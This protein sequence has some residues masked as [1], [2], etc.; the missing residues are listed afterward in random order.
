MSIFFIILATIVVGLV[1]IFLVVQADKKRTSAFQAKADELGWPFHP[2]GDMVLLGRLS[3][4]HLFSQGHSKKMKNLLWAKSP[5]GD[6]AIFGYRYTTGGGDNSRMRRQNV[7]YFESSALKL[8]KFTLR[9]KNIFHKIGGT[10]GYQDIDFLSHPEF[11]KK[12]LLRG[13]DVDAI[14]ALF[15]DDIL[16]FFETQTKVSVEGH[17]QELIYYRAGKR[18]NPEELISFLQDGSEVFKLFKQG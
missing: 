10:M 2:K 4:F 9:P 8:P 13:E 14:D 5:R 17:G 12:Y 15:R 7:A 3:D 1:G 11:S 16:S 18:I 6:V